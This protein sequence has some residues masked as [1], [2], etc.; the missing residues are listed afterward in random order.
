MSVIP[1]NEQI[2]KLDQ[3]DEGW[4]DTHHGI[5]EDMD[6]EGEGEGGVGGERALSEHVLLS[7]CLLVHFSCAYIG[8]LYIYM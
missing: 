3:D 2:V 4:V 8:G 1:E 5:S 6:W 7:H